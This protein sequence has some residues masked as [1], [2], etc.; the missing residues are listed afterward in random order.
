[1][2]AH[3][4]AFQHQPNGRER[5]R[6]GC[7]LPR[8][9]HEIP[10]A[11]RS[12]E[13]DAPKNVATKRAGVVIV[14]NATRLSAGLFDGRYWA[15]TSD[16]QLVE[17][18]QRSEYHIGSLDVIVKTGWP[19]GQTAKYKSSASMSAVRGCRALAERRQ[20]LRGRHLSA[21]VSMFRGSDGAVGPRFRCPARVGQR[22]G[23][24]PKRGGLS[25]RQGPS[26]ESWRQ[27]VRV[28]VLDARAKR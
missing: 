25:T 11:D 9:Q 27:R 18:G 28:L 8:D 6:T 20:R 24:M 21:N 23:G 26:P 5:T 1:M 3:L 13:A 4:M 12:R 15:R 7:S 2:P 19:S 22:F 10:G 17:T 14:E 16:P